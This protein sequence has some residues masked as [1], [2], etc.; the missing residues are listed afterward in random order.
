[1]SY[2]IINGRVLSGGELADA[3]VRLDGDVIDTIGKCA[4]PRHSA[5]LDATGLLVLPGIID[6]HGDAFERS[7]MPRPGIFFDHAVALAETDRNLVA[8][9]ITTAYLGL[10]ISWEPGLRSLEAGRKTVDALKTLRAS[11]ACDVRLQ[12][13]WETFALDAVEAVSAWLDDE[14]RP[15][16][17][18]FNDH[19]TQSL[20]KRTDA[21]KIQSW[22]ERS[23]LTKEEYLSLLERVAGRADEVPGAISALASRARALGVTMFSHDDRLEDR[24]SYR[25]IG[26]SVCDLPLTRAAIEDA[27]APGEHTF[28]GAPDILRAGSPTGALTSTGMIGEGLCT[29]LASDYYYPSQLAAAFNLERKYGLPLPQAWPLVSGNAADAPG[30]PGRG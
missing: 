21:K 20:E 13:R 27:R 22:A 9:G 15:P 2:T 28:L 3:T 8:Q 26:A 16:V 25:G 18:A 30:L 23:G 6:L 17:L 29:V 11:L 7:L 19:T 14:I 12:I 10:T 4:T 24:R 5:V 1:M